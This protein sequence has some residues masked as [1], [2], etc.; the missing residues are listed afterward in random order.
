MTTTL[1][2]AG[3]AFTP[4]TEITD[5]GI[6][7]REDV[8]EAI[9]PRAGMTLPAGAQEILATG[10]T[11]I[12]GFI[13]I[14]IHGAGGHDVMEASSAALRAVTSKVAEY[15]T[16]SLLAT[17]VTAS[18]EDTCWAV[19]GIARY[20]T[21]QYESPELRAE[22][23]GIHFEGP[24]ISKERR[25]V[26]PAKWIQLP[27]V[28]LLDRFL[29]AAAGNARLMTIAPEVMGAMPCIDAAQK[30]GLVISIGHTDANYEQARFAIAR[31][32]RSATHTYNAMRPFS[33]R[34]PGVIGAV[35]TSPEI[36]A[37]LIADGV[38][39]EEGAMKLL[40][41][42]KGA[43]R[44]ILVSDG[45]SATGMPDGKYMLGDIEVIVSNGVCRSSAGI[46]AG[47]TLT[48]DRALRN[49]VNLGIPFSDAVRML[50]LNPASLLGIEFKKGS[51]RVGAD[52]D[53]L[54]LDEGLHVTGVWARGVALN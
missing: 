9:G 18:A 54:L 41:Q 8:I 15:G 19:E 7:I 44:V 4:T 23:L 53:I 30:A 32:A 34:D 37:E 39:V 51:L 27:S 28:E 46:L 11:A 42:A 29:Q 36:N 10:K 33:H 17:T 26:H 3:R 16:T 1:I 5:A 31:G 48:L 38:H 25:G 14:H 47:S 6:L 50:T 43:E 45:L 24:F 12:P 2:H 22:V 20:I 49:I 40:L 35:L 13:D 52:A 21:Q